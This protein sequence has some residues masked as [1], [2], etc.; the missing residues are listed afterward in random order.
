MASGMDFTDKA[1]ET[2]A[3][4]IQLAKDYAHSQGKIPISLG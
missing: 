3:A 2:L 4:S 1:Q